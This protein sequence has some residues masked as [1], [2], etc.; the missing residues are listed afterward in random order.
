MPHPRNAGW[1]RG[2]HWVCCDVCGFD[3]RAS[4][5][6]IRWD[7][8]AVCPQDYEE[9]HPQD[10]LRARKDDPRVW[11]VRTDTG[12]DAV[13]IASL[14]CPV[15]LS[16]TDASEWVSGGLVPLTWGEVDGAS[17]YYVY[18]WEDG[19]TEPTEP[20]Y[21]T[22]GTSFEVPGTL[23]TTYRWYVAAAGIGGVSEGCSGGQRT[24]TYTDIP[25]ILEFVSAEYSTSF[26]EP[27]VTLT[28]QRTGGRQR[29]VSASCSF[30]DGI[31]L[32][33]FD[34]T[35]TTQAVTFEP[36]E[37]TKQVIVPLIEANYDD[38][39][40]GTPSAINYYKFDETSGTVITDSIATNDMTAFSVE[41][42]RPSLNRT[43][44]L[45][46]DGGTGPLG[47]SVG[48]RGN[49][50]YTF[51]TWLEPFE[52]QTS[53]TPTIVAI[54]A[55]N[56]E[57][58]D[59]NFQFQA[60]ISDFTTGQIGFFWEFNTGENESV[61]L[62]AGQVFLGQ[63][64]Y[65]VV[66]RDD[67]A[68]TVFAKVNDGPY[69]SVVYDDGPTGGDN[70]TLRYLRN[71]L[72]GAGNRMLANISHAAIYTSALELDRYPRWKIGAVLDFTATLSD[73]SAGASIGAINETTVE[74]S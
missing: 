30:A 20:T 11:P 18:F 31:A 14:A 13:Q 45:S 1:R 56:D 60:Q 22:S 65:I 48:L 7:G 40:A 36:N 5:I 46:A 10:F 64:N 73:P 37:M 62:V 49:I 47:S 69:V 51:E 25:A 74:I 54:S 34:Y 12:A 58:P 19:D 43:G 50:S 59:N 4:Q 44:G 63:P 8:M 39:V 41:W 32:D 55:V 33:G 16:P 9:R 35:G 28:V 15:L 2:D 38:E 27:S 57:Q 6:R 66:G 42:Q 29:Q 17:L 67:V 24:F 71:E 68:G 61:S 23:E 72:S 3:Y 26:G 70:T 21:I 52:T 53:G